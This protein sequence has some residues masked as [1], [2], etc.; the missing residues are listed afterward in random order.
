[1]S[2]S[3]FEV[4]SNNDVKI[5]KKNEYKL[6]FEWYG[7]HSRIA[8]SLQRI[9]MSEVPTFAIH[10]CEVY[11]NTSVMPDE[12]L[13][14][15]LGLIPLLSVEAD[16]YL[17]S[18]ECVCESNCDMCSVEFNLNITCTD[19][20]YNVT[21]RDLFSNN[22]NIYPIHDSGM[23]E[24]MI[25]KHRELLGEEPSILIVKLKKNQHI[26]IR[27]I[28]KKG[29]GI[30]KEDREGHAKWNPCC[31]ATS[32]VSEDQTSSTIKVESTGVIPPKDIVLKSIDI[33]KNKY[34]L[35]LKYS[36]D[37]N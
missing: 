2:G 6:D 35:L 7:V 15:R 29:L 27:C 32:I 4:R 26:R 9:M 5:L 33:L 36:K 10:L 16:N 20:F 1:M 19:E 17:Y 14:L 28:A 22:P 24:E 21:S 8:H 23:T 30:S 3:K 12:M 25:E 11:D 34:S 31:T 13:V 37:F 18:N